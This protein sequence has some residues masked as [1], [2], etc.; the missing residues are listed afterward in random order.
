[1][2]RYDLKEYWSKVLTIDKIA[3]FAKHHCSEEIKAFL[4]VEEHSKQGVAAAADTVSDDKAGDPDDQRPA[5]GGDRRSNRVQRGMSMRRKSQKMSAKQSSFK[6]EDETAM[7]TLAIGASTSN[8]APTQKAASAEP[9]PLTDA[10]SAVDVSS[11]SEPVPI[12]NSATTYQSQESAPPPA[13]SAAPSS[14]PK[15]VS[16]PTTARM[17]LLGS[18]TALRKD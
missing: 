14:V 11:F 7:S 16:K 10:P 9:S 15:E 6:F 18:I 1:M 3:D 13:L 17:N 5:T 2:C 8:H 12:T 4:E